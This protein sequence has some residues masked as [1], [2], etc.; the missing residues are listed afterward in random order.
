MILCRRAGTRGWAALGQAAAL[1]APLACGTAL[2]KGR[3]TQ[4]QDMAPAWGHQQCGCVS[5]PHGATPGRCASPELTR[6]PQTCPQL[7]KSHLWHCFNLAQPE[8]RRTSSTRVG[9]GTNPNQRMIWHLTSAPA[10]FPV[11]TACPGSSSSPVGVTQP[12]HSDTTPLQIPTVL[13]RE[14]WEMQ[15]LGEGRNG[16]LT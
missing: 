1:A 10:A 9:K 7:Q 5:L 2:G 14:L 16:T 12:C 4:F 3:W 15:T 11:E 6:A 8:I 13:P